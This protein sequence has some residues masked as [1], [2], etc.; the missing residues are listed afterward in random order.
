MQNIKVKAQ[1]EMKTKNKLERLKNHKKPDQ[2]S[3]ERERLNCDTYNSK[4]K[5]LKSD[6]IRIVNSKI[7]QK[8]ETM[9]IRGL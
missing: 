2:Y 9:I 1:S 8:Q 7:I 3:R 6:G 5:K 4:N